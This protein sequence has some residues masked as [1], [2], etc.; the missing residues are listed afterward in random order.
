[1]LHK[2]VKYANFAGSAAT[3]IG[4]VEQGDH[5]IYAGH[6]LIIHFED[7]LGR[8]GMTSRTID[9]ASESPF[10]WDVADVAGLA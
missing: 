2:S 5:G 4:V 1:M 10:M 6:H 3:Y 8:S 7:L 9:F